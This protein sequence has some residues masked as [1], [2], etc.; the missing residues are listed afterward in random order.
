VAGGRA[1]DVLGQLDTL[2]LDLTAFAG[3]GT[4]S[5]TRGP[6]WRFLDMGRRVE[7]AGGMIGILAVALVPPPSATDGSQR[8]EEMLLEIADSSMTYRNRYLGVLEPAPV[9]DLLVTD[10]TNPRS[11]AFQ[12]A[13]L[14][15]H[16]AALPDAASSP[17]LSGERRAVLEAVAAIRLADVEALAAAGPAGDRPELRRLLDLLGA[18]AREFSESITHRYLVH[19]TTQRRLGDA[20]VSMSPA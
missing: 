20:A 1:G 7:R 2:I 9:V 18:A 10:D 16:V 11:I 15:D 4:E 8:L 3:L 13:A 19:A 6:G 5:M 17:V 14:A 12:F